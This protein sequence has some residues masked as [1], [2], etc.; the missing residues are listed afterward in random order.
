[1]TTRPFHVSIPVTPSTRGVYQFTPLAG[2]RVRVDGRS[3][4]VTLGVEEPAAEALDEAP[5]APMQLA[6]MFETRVLRIDVTDMLEAIVT[7]AMKP[8]MK[9][10]E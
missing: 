8:G 9:L 6:V 10:V 2:G 5:R 1:M 4:D 7:E 3:I